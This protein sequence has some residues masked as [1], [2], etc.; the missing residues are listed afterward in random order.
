ML[1]WDIK[2]I[3]QK[4]AMVGVS[5]WAQRGYCEGP[6]KLKSVAVM[7]QVAGF[8][9]HMAKL[10]KHECQVLGSCPQVLFS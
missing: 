6:H 7:P 2:A 8:L 5:E 9:V 10:A 4:M 1:A 3:K